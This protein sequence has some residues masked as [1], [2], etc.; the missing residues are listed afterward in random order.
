[1]Q[2]IKSE[3]FIFCFGARGKSGLHARLLRGIRP[4]GVEIARKTVR[5]SLAT[6]P[7][8]PVGLLKNECGAWLKIRWVKGFLFAS[9]SFP[10]H[11][12]PKEKEVRPKIGSI[13]SHGRVKKEVR[14]DRYPSR[15]SGDET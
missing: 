9:L 2:K 8:F 11:G 5:F 12:S 13:L 7:F 1:M 10:A 3:T 4:E 15:T 6:C 14:A